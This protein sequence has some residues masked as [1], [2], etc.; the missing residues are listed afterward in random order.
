MKQS[1]LDPCLFI[2]EKVICI[3]YVDDLLFWARDDNDI[4]DLAFGLR[5]L[6]ST[7]KRSMMQQGS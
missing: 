7:W 1:E 2:G 4:N 5:D 3:V 6:E